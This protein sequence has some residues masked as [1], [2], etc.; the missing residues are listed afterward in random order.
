MAGRIRSKASRAGEHEALRG[1]F[2]KRAPVRTLMTSSHWNTKRL[3]T[4]NDCV[5]QMS[6]KTFDDAQNLK[7][8]RWTSEPLPMLP[9]TKDRQMGALGRRLA[10]PSG[11]YFFC[12]V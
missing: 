4:G 2:I 8:S 10:L 6:R 1:I 7:P 11:H 3:F 12:S 5:A 9:T